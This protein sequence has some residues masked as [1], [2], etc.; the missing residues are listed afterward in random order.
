MLTS[1]NS[2][3]ITDSDPKGF[4]VLLLLLAGI[5]MIYAIAACESDKVWLIKVRQ[6]LDEIHDAQGRS[7]KR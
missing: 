3:N 7:P 6:L 1:L 4:A 5:Y 2:I